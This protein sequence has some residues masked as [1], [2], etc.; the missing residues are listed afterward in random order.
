MRK[1]LTYKQ[2]RQIL[3]FFQNAHGPVNRPINPDDIGTSGVIALFRACRDYCNGV[4]G[5]YGYRGDSKPPLGKGVS[6]EVKAQYRQHLIERLDKLAIRYYE[7][8]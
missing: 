3:I 1:P 8:L 4:A 2:Q 7:D 6:P 5:N